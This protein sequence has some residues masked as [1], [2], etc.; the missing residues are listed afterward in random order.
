METRNIEPLGYRDLRSH[1]GHF[2]VT[3][4]SIWNRRTH[5]TSAAQTSIGDIVWLLSE[6]QLKKKFSRDLDMA[7]QSFTHILRGTCQC[8]VSK[9]PGC[10][11]YESKLSTGA[12]VAS[13]SWPFLSYHWM[14]CICCLTSSQLDIYLHL[15]ADLAGAVKGVKQWSM[16]S[17]I[18]QGWFFL[19]PRS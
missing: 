18:N 5:T 17:C 8:E 16:N 15:P 10:P 7:E 9:Q 11:P 3:K 1:L 13:L 6:K 12:L 14:L 4:Q 19:I 2:L